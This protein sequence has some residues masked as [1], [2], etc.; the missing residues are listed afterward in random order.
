MLSSNNDE[1]VYVPLPPRLLPAFYR[2][3]ATIMGE[4]GE[5]KKAPVLTPD[6]QKRNATIIDLAINA[7]RDIGAEHFPVS[8]ADLHAAYLRTNPGISKGTTLDSFGATINYHTINM[9]S[10]FPDPH[11]KRK[12][13]NWLSRPLFKRVSYGQYMLLDSYQLETFQQYI[14]K[15]DPS[16]YQDEYDADNVLSVYPLSEEQRRNLPHLSE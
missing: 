6:P 4:S 14:E 15:D 5:E 9:R 10:R 8:L 7:A 13:A 1:F 11:N 12:L 3:V 16:I 2:W